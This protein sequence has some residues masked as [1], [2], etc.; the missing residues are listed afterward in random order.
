M[1]RVTGASEGKSK[2]SNCRSRFTRRKVEHTRRTHLLVAVVHSWIEARVD[3]RARLAS[4]TVAEV[5]R[6]RV[7]AGPGLGAGAVGGAAAPLAREAPGLSSRPTCAVV[8]VAAAAA[9]TVVPEVASAGVLAGGREVTRG[10]V[11]ASVHGPV[12]HPAVVHLDAQLAVALPLGAVLNAVAPLAARCA[13]GAARARL[14]HRL[15]GQVLVA[16]SL[17]HCARRL[18]GLVAEVAGPA[19]DARRVAP[20]QL[21]R[22]WL[23]RRAVEAVAT[24]PRVAR[25][26]AAPGERGGALG[27][28]VAQVGAVQVGAGVHRE[29]ARAVDD[30]TLHAGGVLRA[31]H[32]AVGGGQPDLGD[33]PSLDLNPLHW[34]LLPFEGERLHL[35]AARRKVA[36]LGSEG[37]RAVSSPEPEGHRRV[38]IGC[39]VQRAVAVVLAEA[40]GA[41]G[42]HG[43]RR[44]SDKA[45]QSHKSEKA[46]LCLKHRN[47]QFYYQKT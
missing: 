39:D 27:V 32:A 17:A 5:A 16:I 46:H 1:N 11:V 33:S 29:E 18:V 14:A 12:A 8:H 44:S 35:V 26:A 24:V 42:I 13:G 19:L 20:R 45:A 28:E 7:A 21:A 9:V 43:G 38:R 40:F 2:E 22:A 3:V 15:A 34:Q 25:A 4:A 23:A 6:A 30:H 41:H 36:R 10:F 31:V 37:G 47:F